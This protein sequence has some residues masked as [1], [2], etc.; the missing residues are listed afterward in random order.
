[1]RAAVDEVDADPLLERPDVPAEGRLRDGARFR[2][3]EKLPDSASATKSS[4][5][6]T[7]SVRLS[8]PMG[9]P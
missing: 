6:S 2:R 9:T 3:R 7:S 4:S 8:G 5:H 1:M